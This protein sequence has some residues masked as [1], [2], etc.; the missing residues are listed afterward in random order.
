VDKEGFDSDLTLK[1]ES[2]KYSPARPPA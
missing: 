2:D 1:I